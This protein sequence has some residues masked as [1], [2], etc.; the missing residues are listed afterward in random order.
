[1]DQLAA[2]PKERTWVVGP[3]ALKYEGPVRE[4]LGTQG[5][6]AFN[7]LHQ[8]SAMSIARLAYRAW[9]AGS[10]PTLKD[11]KPLY[12]RVPSVDEKKP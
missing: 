6:F 3:G 1:M 10:R 2:L 4:A 5:M 8:P 11:L 9:Q 12:L 7:A